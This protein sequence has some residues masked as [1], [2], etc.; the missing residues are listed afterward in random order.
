MTCV[1]CAARPVPPGSVTCGNSYCQE[2][3]FWNNTARNAR[4]GSKAERDARMN[5][6]K[7]EMLATPVRRC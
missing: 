7:A 3:D 2:A 5:A 6:T 1:Y 4:K